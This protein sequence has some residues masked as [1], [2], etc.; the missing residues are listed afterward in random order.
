MTEVA[1]EGKATCQACSKEALLARR[2]DGLMTCL[3]CFEALTE[4]V[5]GAQ[6]APTRALGPGD[7][8]AQVEK[9]KAKAD[10]GERPATIDRLM[11]QVGELQER[12]KDLERQL[13]AAPSVPELPGGRR[14]IRIPVRRLQPALVPPDALVTVRFMP[15]QLLSDGKT[16]NIDPHPAIEVEIWHDT[17]PERAQKAEYRLL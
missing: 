17:F 16:P 9:L 8:A 1:I 2:A 14:V 13:E 7:V 12:I 11:R 10:L 3:E 6:E 4:K 5:K 15:D